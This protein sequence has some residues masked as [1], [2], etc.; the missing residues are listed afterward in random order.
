VAQL[1]DLV[2]IGGTLMTDYKLG[3]MWLIP[4]RST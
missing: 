4:R 3:V 1:L 2:A